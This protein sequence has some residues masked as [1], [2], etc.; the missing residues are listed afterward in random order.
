MQ[1]CQSGECKNSFSRPRIDFD[2]LYGLAKSEEDAD[3]REDKLG[4]AEEEVS[5]GECKRKGKKKV[6]R[7]IAYTGDPDSPHLTEAERRRLRRSAMPIYS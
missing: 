4:E 5:E 3:N 1:N 6:G 7:P 2:G